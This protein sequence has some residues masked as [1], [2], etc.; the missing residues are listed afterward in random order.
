MNELEAEAT[1]KWQAREAAFQEELQQTQQRLSALQKEKKGGERFI[2][3]KEQQDEIV[4]IINI[5]LV[6]VLVVLFGLL[7]GY[8][9]R[10]RA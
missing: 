4:K 3:S 10:K 9:R 1:K 5:A 6:P 2:L 8:L 7:R